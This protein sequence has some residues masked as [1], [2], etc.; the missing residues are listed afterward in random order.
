MWYRE[1]VR[2]TPLE[3]RDS[4]LNEV[5]Q[6]ILKGDVRRLH[7]VIDMVTR[8]TQIYQGRVCLTPSYN[9]HSKLATLSVFAACRGNTQ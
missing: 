4:I 6:I 3:T 9:T 5:G 7:A 1:A 8:C 2:L